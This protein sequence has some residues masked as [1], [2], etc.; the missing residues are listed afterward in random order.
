M[1]SSRIATSLLALGM[2][3]PATWLMADEGMWLFNDL[4][5][6]YLQQRYGFTPTPEWARHLMLASVRFN[7]GG[8]ASF[9]SS[10]GL[11]LT[12]HHVG[13][14]TLQ[15]IST[16]EH[17]YLKDGFY[18]KTLSDEIK[19]PDLELNQLISIEDVTDR[20]QAAVTENM[21]PAK[22]VVARRTV[23]AVIEKESQAA[24]GLRSDVITLY[25]GGRYHLYRYKKY[26]DVRLVWAPK[27]PLR[28]LAVMPTT[29]NTLGTT[30][31]PVSSASTRMTS[32]PKSRITSSGRTTQ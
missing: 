25:G 15:K 24:T 10:N 12:N 17:N 22:A 18:A 5:T 20:V 1:T 3:L 28:F 8:S 23:M 6:H 26:T 7:S 19:A 31:M 4:P 9:V 27:Q 30:W 21:T 2:A 32:R 13:A 14:D 16:P 11:V 29:S